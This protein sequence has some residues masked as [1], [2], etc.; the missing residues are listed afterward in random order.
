[1]R[2]LIGRT[3]LAIM[4]AA[5]VANA[6]A[7]A[8]LDAVVATVNK[9]PILLSDWEDGLRFEAFLQ[10]RPMTSFSQA[11]RKAALDRLI[12]RELL[13]QQMQADYNP[14]DEQVAERISSIRA[15]VKG[16]ETDSGWRSK[17]AEYGLTESALRSAV[18]AQLQVMRFVDLR[19][20]AAV[21]ISREDVQDYYQQKL[22]PAL[23]KAGVKPEPLQQLAPRIREL[24]VQQ[25]LQPLLDSWL[26]NLRD[27]SVVHLSGE[28]QGSG[29][30]PEQPSKPI[31][32]GQD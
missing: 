2:T 7:P 1:M 9:H 4:L 6:Q 14:T 27:Q 11:E 3:I 22:V 13:L 18:K 31:P 12:D 25:Q 17:L 19:L 21:S 32:E 23:E 29:T 28:F 10:G 16:A 15:Q 20:R 24:L 8:H 30:E 5:T 26:A